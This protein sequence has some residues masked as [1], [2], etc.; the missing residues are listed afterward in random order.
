MFLKTQIFEAINLQ[1]KEKECQLYEAMRCISIF[2][3]SDCRKLLR[4]LKKDYYRRISY[5]TY[6]TKSKQ[7]L[8]SSINLIDKLVQRSENLQK[9]YTNHLASVVARIYLESKEARMQPFITEFKTLITVDEKFSLFKSFISELKSKDFNLI[10]TGCPGEFSKLGNLCL[11]RLLMARVFKYAMYPNGEID[12][13]RDT[14][15]SECLR[16]LVIS[17]YEKL[18][19]VSS[20][21]ENECPWIPAQIEL[22]RLNVYKTPQ[23]KLACIRKCIVTIMNLLGIAK[24]P[25][26]AD[27]LNP[28]LI[29]VII[30]ANPPAFL[31]NVQ[32][33]EGYFGKNLEFEDYY[34]AQFMFA[35]SYIKACLLGNKATASNE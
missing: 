11:E 17:P 16:D 12:N 25:V 22:K 20:V 6:L 18:I 14:K 1:D 23:D 29:Y 28:V 24:S 27:D 32:Y 5:M 35:F 21:Y 13:Y 7:N 26:C 9:K 15:L 31:S 3:D 19:G 4:S 10:W 33:I 8:I 30:K 2:N 34:W